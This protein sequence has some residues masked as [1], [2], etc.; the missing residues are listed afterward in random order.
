[1]CQT[2]H[3]SNNVLPEDE[4][5]YEL[6][7]DQPIRPI[8]TNGS[9]KTDD[10]VWSC[11]FN[12]KDCGI[13]NDISVGQYFKLYSNL[14]KPLFGKQHALWLNISQLNTNPS[15]ARLVTPYFESKHHNKGC[16]TIDYLI[17][18]KGIKELIVFQ[19]DNQNQCIYSANKNHQNSDNSDETLTENWRQLSLTID[20]KYGSSPRFFIETHFNNRAHNEGIIALS[21][22][23]F[24]FKRCQHN[25]VNYCKE[26]IVDQNKPNTDYQNDFP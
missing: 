21:D 16:L 24:I 17:Q 2:K 19:Q 6:I 22:I 4:P 9:N 26:G 13:V 8:N 23:K 18:G 15:G 12:G 10:Y 3:L 5:E 7:G 1:M 20:L 11:D 14:I 25:Y